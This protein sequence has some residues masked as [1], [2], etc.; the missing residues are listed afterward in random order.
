MTLRKVRMR[1]ALSHFI[2]DVR[3]YIDYR[4]AYV[5]QDSPEAAELDRAWHDHKVKVRKAG[6]Q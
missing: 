1:A 6:K 3:D 2:E 5:D 4:R